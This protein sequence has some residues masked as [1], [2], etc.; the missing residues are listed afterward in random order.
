MKFNKMKKRQISRFYLPI[1]QQSEIN[2]VNIY[3]LFV[4]EVFF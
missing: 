4:I 3:F 1:C 2:V